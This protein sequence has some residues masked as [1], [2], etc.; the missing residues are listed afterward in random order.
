MPRVR[1]LW[2][3]AIFTVAVI[4]VIGAIFMRPVLTQSAGTPTNTTATLVAGENVPQAA[5]GESASLIYGDAQGSESEHH[6]DHDDQHE[7][8]DDD[9]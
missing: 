8:H 1:A 2:I 3:S 5:G 6:S 9:D 4:L 7:E